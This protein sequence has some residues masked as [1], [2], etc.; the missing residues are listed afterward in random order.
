MKDKKNKV[1]AMAMATTIA[2]TTMAPVPTTTVYAQELD[3]TQIETK[4]KEESKAQDITKAEAPESENK[5]V[6]TNNKETSNVENDKKEESTGN[7]EN[8]EDK[9]EDEKNNTEEKDKVENQDNKENTE[10]AEI[11]DSNEKNEIIENTEDKTLEKVETAVKDKDLSKAEEDKDNGDKDKTV[12]DKATG[13]EINE[14]NFPDEEFRKFIVDFDTDGDNALSE[15][16]IGSVD[17]IDVSKT[18]VSNL[19]G[20]EHFVNLETLIC[21]GRPITN[22]DVSS[23][24]KLKTLNCYNTKLASLNIGNNSNLT[25]ININDTI[26]LNDYIITT[27]E[28]N[29]K[30]E[31]DIMDINNVTVDSPLNLDK[32]TGVVSNYG[33]EINYKYNCGSSQN[34]PLN[35]NVKVNVNVVEINETNVPDAEFRKLIGDIKLT[36]E[37]INNV[38]EISTQGY[39]ITNL[40]GI[41]IFTNLKELNCFEANLTAPLDLSK[42][43]NLETLDCSDS[44]IKEIN[45]ENN[46]NLNYLNCSNNDILS[47]DVSK[48]DKLE[49]LNCSGTKISN[50]DVTSSKSLKV[51]DCYEMNVDNLTIKT[52]AALTRLLCMGSENKK[53]N[54]NLDISNSNILEELNCSNTNITELNL[55]NN[56]KLRELNCSNTNITEL[57]LS[58]NKELSRLICANT[59]ITDLNVSN[60]EKLNELDCRD[61]IKLNNINLSGTTN[62]ANLTLSDTAISSLDVSHITNLASLYLNNTPIKELDLT[63]NSMLGTLDCSGT[64]ITKLDL[65]KNANLTQIF[66]VDTKIV[67]LDIGTG[68]NIYAFTQTKDE[69]HQTGNFKTE[70]NF[71]VTDSTFS[72]REKLGF[73]EGEIKI[74]SGAILNGDVISNYEIGQPIVYEYTVGSYEYVSGAQPQHF[75]VTM[76]VTLNPVKAESAI[77]IINL[78]NIKKVYDGKPVNLTKDDCQITG[79]KG[80]VTFTY[81]D[82]KGTELS[83]APTE[84]GKYKVKAEVA[85]TTYY[86]SAE[87]VVDFEITKA[88]PN[89][90]VEPTNLSAKTGS[91]L[92]TIALPNGWEWVNPDETVIVKNS[93][94]KARIKVDDKNYDYTGVQGYNSGYVER[95][96]KVVVSK[97]KNSWKVPP[98]INGWTYEEEASDPVGTPSYGTVTFTYSDSENGTFTD[99]VPTKAGTW[100]MKATVSESDEYTGLEEKVK[101]TIEKAKAKEVI[102]PNN[103]SAVQ[104]DELNTINLPSGWEWVTPNEKVTTKN[105]GYKARIKVDDKNYDYTGVQGY[106]ANGHY[107]ERTLK[108]VVS[109]NK[110]SWKVNPSINGWTYGEKA[111]SPVGS[112]EHGSVEFTYS[113]SPTGNFEKDVPKEAGTWYMKASVLASDE[114]TGLNEIV[115]FTIAKANAT[116]VVNP[117][118]LS[119]VQDNELSTIV[120]PEG[121]TWVNP[122]EIATVKNNGY[123]ARLKVDDKNYDYT[124]VEGYNEAGHYVERTLQV[125]VAKGEN[126]WIISPAIKNWTYNQAPNSPVGSAKNGTVSFTYSNSKTGTF[127]DVVPTEAGIWYMKATVAESEEYKELSEVV[128]FKIEKANAQEII[129]PNNLSAVQDDELNTINLPSGWEW[130]TPNQKVTTK[131]NGYKARLKVDDKNYDYTGVEGYNSKGSYVERT[132]KVS[133]SKGENAWTIAP[134][135][136]GWTYGEK[137]KSPVG[138]AEH[139]DVVFTYSNSKTGT[140]TDKVPTEAGKWYMKATV[141]SSDE[142]KG[143]NEIVEFTIEKATIKEV[144]NPSNLSGVQDNELSTIVLPEGWTWVNPTEIATVKNNGYLA[145]LKVDDKNYDYTGVEGYN[146]DE[147]YVERTL[148]VSVAKGEN[149]WI[150]SPAIKNW[151]YNQAPN[152]PVGS[153]K[154]GTVSFT[155]SN[156]KTGTFTEVVPTEA[157]IWYMKATVAE[158]EE[159]KELSEI[160]EFTIEK[161]IP[162]YEAPKDIT[163]TYGQTLK[164]VILPEGFSWKNGE[165]VVGNAGTNKFKISYT[166]QDT[167]N[168]KVVNN[169]EIDIVVKQAVNKWIEELSIEGWTYGEKPN[170]PVASAQ[171]GEVKFTYSNTKGRAYTGEIPTEAGTWYVKAEVIGNDN[172]TGISQVKEFK[173]EK[174]VAPEIVLPDNLS[175]VQDDKLDSVSLPENWTWVDKSQTVTVKNNGYKARLKVDDKNYDYTKV[176]GYNED[177]GY[178]E[179]VLQ[180]S[181]SKVQNTWKVTPSIKGWTYG[182]KANTPVG[183][184]K[185]GDVIFTYSNSKTGTFTD[186]V[187]TDAGKW[188]MKAT[189][190]ATDEYTGFNEII[191]FEIKKATPKFE[192][193]KDIKEFYGQTLEDIKLP[194]GFTWKDDK[195]PVGNVGTNKFIVIYTPDDINNYEIVENIE[196]DVIVEKVKNNWTEDISIEDWTYGDKAS[197]PSASGK[198]GEVIYVYSNKKDGEYTADVPTEAGKWYVKAVVEETENYYGLESKALVFNITPKDG[199]QLSIS[200]IKSDKDL[201][202]LIIKDG[203]KILDSSKD[204][205]VTKKQEGNTITVTITFK[206]NY[207][208]TIIKTYEVEV[209]PSLPQTGEKSNI[210]LWGLLLT[211]TGGAIAFITGKGNKRIRKEK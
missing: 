120:L 77:S 63:K 203:S 196:I 70:V 37:E 109:K 122:T 10:E 4:V 115:E 178:V 142:Y 97:N 89:P 175:A 150:I 139:G 104:G 206:G 108:V 84:A 193:P 82:S 98:S 67:N 88:T 68:K 153:A 32:T 90:V 99:V 42:N 100:Y 140:F 25:T 176:E 191:E 35:L 71:T 38:T 41:E 66:F 48:N 85:E 17:S 93:G 81:Y 197:N 169:I 15:T 49:T 36:Q 160:V 134:Q 12:E 57:N 114:Y 103:L 83:S 170:K 91:K 181:V 200:E 192:I 11:K 39:N 72:V 132:L 167:N 186:V 14:T 5:G 164:E 62:L 155:Y 127:T 23:N 45:L 182:E 44:G 161:A 116:E 54:I 126:T 165:E 207:T 154:N 27:P 149:T 163:A 198:F 3:K 133:V 166:P 78:D 50:L 125:S 64:E 86:K 29:I 2:V 151:T 20:I 102:N 95:T 195:Q 190:L 101:F 58:N 129:I 40:K 177:G 79:S 74:T 146:E 128:E 60:M 141:L 202:N 123:L 156:S 75:D 43:V 65:S 189:V 96:L 199:T 18:A 187:P 185:Y 157:G 121:W 194:E 147:H 105:N 8:N 210:G 110:N 188:Y 16:E 69:P 51:L 130:V 28:F 34:G 172:Y 59:N 159:Y 6:E 117:N 61:S 124:G 21:T 173:I 180:V 201:D 208:G 47:L 183:D 204:Y 87:T 53:V 80:A 76:E 30:N 46:V 136:K 106:N 171:F 152:S 184:S 24:T 112:A 13:I 143:L 31:L 113:N 168:Y 52:N 107:V 162:N 148:Q 26:I 135:I 211:I 111:N 119:G 92:S 209:K 73:N 158:S 1:T 205:K 56:P 145:R 22:L 33:S 138:S 174:A 9:I 19:A 144:V 118:N 131:N 179:R 94:Y 7:K 55:V 137:V